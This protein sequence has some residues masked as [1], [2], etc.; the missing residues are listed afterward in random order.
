MYEQEILEVY[1]YCGIRSFPVDCDLVLE[2][3]GFTVLPYAQAANGDP[4]ELKRLKQISPDG[5]IVRGESTLYINEKAYEKRQLFTK[6]HEIG[7][8]VMVSDDE[9]V[10]NT[11]ASHFLAPR[12]VV[13]AENLRTADSIAAYFGISISAANIVISNLMTL[14]P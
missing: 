11:F 10:A 9:D 3:F 14:E 6:A 8:L 4:E 5:F 2:K 1:E 13:F 7:H 12:L